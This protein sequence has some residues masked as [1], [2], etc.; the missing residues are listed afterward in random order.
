MRIVFWHSYLMFH[1]APY[2]REL[3]ELEGVKVHWA[4]SELLPE[5]YRQR[6]YPAPDVGKVRV[7][8]DPDDRAIET[9]LDLGPDTVHVFFGFRGMPLARRAFELSKVRNVRRIHMSENRYEPGVA[10][11]PRWFAYAIDGWR[12]RRWLEA[13]LCIGFTGRY[14]GLRFF[15]RC[16]YPAEKI[17]PFLHLVERTALSASVQVDAVPRRGEPYR[18]LFVGQL[19]PRKRVDLLLDALSCI[20]DLSWELTVVGSGELREQLAQQARELKMESSV[21]FVQNIDNAEVFA[22]MGRSDIL[23][24]PSRFDGWGAVVS[25]ALSTGLP[26]VCSDRCGASDLLVGQPNGYVFSA[27]DVVDLQRGI[28]YA[29]TSPDILKGEPL[30]KWARRITGSAAAAYFVDIVNYL[31]AGATQARPECPWLETHAA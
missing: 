22:L 15:S 23:V 18:L 26:V 9:L 29:L 8:L 10:L 25:E 16:G 14:G 19:I 20:T 21:S 1:Q 24:L 30:R 12:N 3:A 4:V 11:L 28:R 2:I 17:F 27:D 6:G 13:F 7:V 5:A 31:D